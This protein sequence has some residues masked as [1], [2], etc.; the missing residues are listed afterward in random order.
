MSDAGLDG[1]LVVIA[2]YVGA[3]GCSY[4]FVYLENGDCNL[5]VG[6][7]LLTY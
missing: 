4:S 5:L 7:G 6:Y 3:T 2:V 1:C